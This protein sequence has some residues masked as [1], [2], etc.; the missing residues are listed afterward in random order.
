M[1][2]VVRGILFFLMMGQTEAYAI[3]AYPF[4]QKITQPDGTSLIIQLHGD[5]WF[6]WITTE[7]GYRIIRN[8]DGIFEYAG[9]LKSGVAV[10]SGLRVN[11]I[12]KRSEKEEEYLTRIPKNLGISLQKL[13]SSRSERNR[14]PGDLKSISADIVRFPSAGVRKNLMILANFN[15][16]QTTY[17]QGDFHN[18]MNQENYNGTG[19][20]RDF[21]LENSGG[22]LDVSTTVT[23]WVTL[24]NSHDY[25]GPEGKWGE[26]AF[27]AVTA[28][29]NQ[30]IDF[31]EFDN[32][33]DG[34]VDA[35][36][37]IHQGP[38]QEVTSNTSDIWSHSWYLSSAGY[39]QAERTFNNAVVDNYTVQPEQY[40]QSGAMTTIGVICHEFGHSLGAV[41]YYDVDYDE[42]G[43]YDG[44]GNWDL[45]ANGS[46]NGNPNG[47]LPAH[48][49][50]YEKNLWGW[51]TV[52]VISNPQSI[53]LEP[54]VS[55][56]VVLKINTSTEG[57]YFLFENRQRA[58][59]DSDLP[60]EGLLIYHVDQNY[61]DVNRPS[62]M[63]NIGEHQGLYPIAAGGTI[64][65]ASCP[66]P[67]T[68]I[69]TMFTDDTTPDARDWAG[70]PSNQSVTDI[71]KDGSN[72]KF[73][74][75]ALQDGAP[76]SMTLALQSHDQVNILWQLSGEAYP[77]LLAYS[78]SDNFGSPLDGVVYEAGQQLEGGGEVLY[79]GDAQTTFDH[80][81]LNE[82]T[83]YYYRL[84]SNRGDT[85]SAGL[86]DN[87]FTNA[88]P[89][90][91]F[92]WHD[93]FEENLGNWSQEGINE[94]RLLWTIY[95]ETDGATSIIPEQSYEGAHN[96]LFF[97][98]G[99][100]NTTRLISPVFIPEA[101]EV[102]R[103][104]FH[105]AQVEWL[106]DQ[107]ELKILYLEEGDTEWQ[108]LAHYINS[109]DDWVEQVLEFNPLS[110]FQLAFEATA[111][112]GHGI[113]LD[114]I[115]V[116]K[117]IATYSVLINVTDGWSPI[118]GALVTFNGEQ[119]VTGQDG[120]VVFNN[121]PEGTGYNYHIEFEGYELYENLID[122]AQNMEIDVALSLSTGRSDL[123]AP[124]IM[125]YPNPSSG[126]FTIREGNQETN[127][128]LEVY[129]N[130]GV[131]LFGKL[132]DNK[133]TGID[134]SPY[135]DGIYF[136]KVKNKN[137]ER[138]YKL[139]LKR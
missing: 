110:A 111:N 75:M 53:I 119:L 33:S 64:N 92:P 116:E 19:S 12:H 14:T 39:S 131:L 81:G 69:V 67:G 2:W 21:Y 71:Q 113:V 96:A 11:D 78:T 51:N 38:G 85:Y 3:P 7:D 46:Y 137:M 114:N 58:G 10:P 15:D 47:S 100:G 135:P 133:E 17:T 91:Q 104:R 8:N 87:I 84:W 76:Q 77:V 28:A 18:L 4:P 60:G 112:Y 90:N 48:I 5:E 102:Y 106:G 82:K 132:L 20:F 120:S 125:I 138:V 36:A 95:S 37:I 86:S 103:L 118:P 54:V 88:A 66:F 63:V 43:Q 126:R 9:L 108:E 42:N 130:A 123:Q 107:D 115:W 128:E 83:T 105:H 98:E 61:L 97:D 50:A 41:D 56:G 134:L 52:Q 99:Y 122:V 35:V 68:S 44:M 109:I 22:L 89:V 65:A 57:E 6:N 25:Y 32:D 49:N 74:F 30:G 70:N 34:K 23:V 73:D 79:V 62:N 29:Y 124:D 55:S 121:V 13:G 72:V 40:G 80:I 27:D 101:G 59:F 136:L 94:S 139:I 1:M 31:S 45:M 16:T 93:G 117:M 127:A 129:N 26:F 24:P